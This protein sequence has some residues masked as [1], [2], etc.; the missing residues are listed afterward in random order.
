MKD[1]T[2]A[3]VERVLRRYLASEGYELSKRLAN[4]ETGA[5]VI[6]R[7][8]G[9]VIYIEVIGFDRSPPRRSKDFYESFFRAVSR[10]N[11]GVTSVVIALPSRFARGMAQRARHHRVAWARIGKAFPELAIWLVDIEGELCHP[12]SWN[13]WLRA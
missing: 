13:E 5:D 3:Q 2:S 11:E 9:E 4:G 6:A 12:R 1:P 7:R 10:L 8:G